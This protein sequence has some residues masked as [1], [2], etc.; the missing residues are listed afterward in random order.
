M[1]QHDPLQ[2]LR[3]KQAILR[4]R[5]RGVAAGLHNGLF[6]YGRPGTG[7]SYTVRCTL[8]EV[9]RPHMIF[10][11]HITPQGLFA[12]FK[13]Y[14]DQVLVFDDVNTLLTDKQS[15]GY[16]LAAL[17]DQGSG[18]ERIIRYKRAGR[19]ETCCFTGGVILLC[20]LDPDEKADP[21][22][23][24]LKSRVLTHEYNPS[25]AEMEAMMRDI[26]SRGWPAG[27]AYLNGAE[28]HEVADFLLTQS[29]RFELRLDLR[30]LTKA[31]T[32]RYQFAEGFTECD[33]KDLVVSMI[34]ERVGEFAFTGE[35]PKTNKQRRE[36][37]NAILLEITSQIQD[38]EE[39]VKMWIER[40]GKSQATFYRRLASLPH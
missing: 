33:W 14:A 16:M 38:P 25:E 7:K 27:D 40:T 1:E 18:A 36:D 22:V 10:N 23:D 28:C 15:V 12:S 21:A 29:K 30:H 35:R 26:C 37:E 13:K 9:K 17:G 34:R 31:L 6:I 5:T 24:A 2:T 8:E 39:R 4:D 11:G 19:D 3:Q 32:D 20:N